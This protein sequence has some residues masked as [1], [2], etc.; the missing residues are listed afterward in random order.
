VAFPTL[1]A[2]I[3]QHDDS[4]GDEVAP[5]QVAR[6]CEIAFM[7]GP[8]EVPQLVRAVMLSGKDVFDMKG[9]EGQVGFMQS[10]IL[11]TPSGTRA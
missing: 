7:T 6:F 1:F 5:A 2:W 9:E 4:A 8:G 11:A 10:A 3:E